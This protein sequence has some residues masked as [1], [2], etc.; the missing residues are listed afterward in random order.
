MMEGNQYE[1]KEQL[2][3]AVE[4]KFGTD[5]RFHT[6]SAEGMTAAEIVDFLAKKGK[7]LFANDDAFTVDTTKI[8]NH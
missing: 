1:S 7:F 4:E 3:K 5:E 2:V 8:C 6:C